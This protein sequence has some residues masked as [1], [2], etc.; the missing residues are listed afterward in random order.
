M[1]TTFPYLR[2]KVMCFEHA[3]HILFNIKI[4]NTNINKI[5]FLYM[6]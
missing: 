1:Y 5:I 4:F 2:Y 3:L 6:L